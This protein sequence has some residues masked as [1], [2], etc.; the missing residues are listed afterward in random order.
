MNCRMTLFEHR[1]WVEALLVGALL[2]IAPAALADPIAGQC[3]YFAGEAFKDIQNG[4][5]QTFRTTLA[6]DCADA[7]ALAQ[8]SDPEMRGRALVYLGQL[9][10]YRRVVID[11]LVAR[12]SEPV[13]TRSSMRKAITPLSEAGAYLIAYRMGL[14]DQRDDWTE[15]R[16]S[17]ASADPRPRL[18]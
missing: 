11:L 14:I 18:D 17:V 10:A 4:E 1:R 5:G 3:R 8:S 15:W 9:D 7:A 16:R 13:T 2:T 12:T 6:Q